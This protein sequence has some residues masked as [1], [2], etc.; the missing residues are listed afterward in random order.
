MSHGLIEFNFIPFG[1]SNGPAV[2]QELMHIVSK[3]SDW[4][5]TAYLDGI[6]LVQLW[7]TI[8]IQHVEIIFGKLRQHNLR[9]KLKKCSLIQSE[10]TYMG[11][12]ETNYLGFVINE[13][14]IKADEKK[15][16]AKKVEAI[17]LLAVPTFVREAK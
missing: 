17:R 8:S 4:F 15:V 6:I 2:F 11:F 12:L 16:E 14:E 13:E 10:T 7:R 3:G 1:L 5:A 9:L